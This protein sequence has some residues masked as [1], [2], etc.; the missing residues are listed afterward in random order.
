MLLVAA[1]GTKLLS[2]LETALTPNLST[3]NPSLRLAQSRS[4]T[5]R[6]LLLTLLFLQAVG[7]QRTWDLRGYAGQALALLTGRQRAYGYRYTERFLAELASVGAD[8]PLTEAL[9]RWTASLWEPKQLGRN[10]PVPVF[11]VD[12]HRKPVYADS[13]IPRG[14]IGRTGKILGCRALVVLH[15]QEGHLLLATTHRGDQHLTI[16]LPTILR[17]YEQAADP[18]SLKRIVVDREG[19]SAEFL[20]GLAGEGRTVVTVLR[21]DQY[22]GLESFREVEAF[23]PLQA[24]R[25]GKVIRE[26]AL[27]RIA[28]PLPDHPGQELE[29][30]VALIRDW[31]RLVP[32]APSSEEEDRPL[33]WDEKPDGTHEYWLDEHWQAKPLPAPPMEPKLIPIVTTA[34][35]ADAVELVQTY[36]RR[37]PVQENAI[38]DWLIPLGIDINHGYA[39]TVVANSEVTKKRK[40]LQKRL[41]NVKCWTDGARKRIHNAS[42]LY[43]KRCKLT[44]ERATE[45][46]YALNNHQ[47]EMEQQG[48]ADFLLRK[49]IKEEK[50]VAD[51]EIEEYRQRQW[52]A[53]HTS[54]KEFAKCEKYCREQRELLRALEDLEQQEREMYELDNHKDQ[55]MTVFK[56]ALA[57]LGMWVR[58]HYFPVEYTHATWQRLQVFFQL[59]GRIFWGRDQVE[60]ELKRFNDRALNRDLEALCA[61]VA[62]EQPRLPDG[63]RLLFR[64]QGRGILLL[65]A[66]EKEV[67]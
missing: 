25:Q 35:D 5:L 20:A 4:S 24:D 9:A 40:A 39:K 64:V 41:D 67:A 18:E 52:K 49:T 56:V 23:V 38:R 7:L 1:Q 2:C 26:V 6:G 21:T 14:L 31:R 60:V 27:A 55:V 34:A 19:M 12:G 22:A 65:D 48:V 51:A 17:H 61:K 63:R 28:L 32:K 46:Y 37:W 44:K 66:R 43:A 53:Y 15:D 33:R 16:G 11:Y 57:N 42:K 10:S 62:Q 47:I 30:R 59:P 13:L 50:T 36:T 54:N 45:L 58:D 3:A 8:T 29:M